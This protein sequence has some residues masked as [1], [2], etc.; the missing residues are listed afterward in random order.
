MIKKSYI[1]SDFSKILANK[2]LYPV[3]QFSLLQCKCIDEFGENYL[4]D[5]NVVNKKE[6]INSWYYVESKN[7]VYFNILVERLS[8]IHKKDLS[9]EFWKR[10]FSQGLMRQI[11]FLHQIF[12]LLEKKF[13]P[14]YFEFST[15]DPSSYFI[16]KDFEEQRN[17][18]GSFHGQEQLFSIYIDIF[19]PKLKRGTFSISQKK[20]TKSFF[21]YLIKRWISNLTKFLKYCLKNKR[22]DKS[23]CVVLLLGCF[24]SKYH[25]DNLIKKSSRKIIDL[26][27]I[28]YSK[29]FVMNDNL[30]TELSNLPERVDRFDKFFFGSLKFL[31]PKVFLEGL[32]YNLLCSKK[33]LSQYPKLSYIVSEAW[34]SDTKINLF[35]AYA[36][37]VKGVK[38]YYNEH[39]CIF[40]P[41]VGNFVD[42]QSRSIDKYLTFGWNSP[43]GKFSPTSSLF[44]FSISK[45]KKI[46]NLDILYVSNPV[47]FFFPTYSSS[48]SNWGYGSIE[49]LKYVKS[50]FHLLP[51]NLKHKISYRSYPKD[52]QITGLRFDKEKLLAKYL[53]GINFVSSFKF[54]GE[55]CKEQM[56]SSKLVI[57]DFLSTSYLES[58]HM[59]IPTICFW[60]PKSMSLKDDYADFFDDLVE[61]KIMHTNP[62]SAAIHLKE[63]HTNPQTWW[64]S[65]KIQDLK[66]NWLNRNFGQPDVLVNYLLK[67]AQKSF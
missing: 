39:N 52:Y 42:F 40:H 3:F 22:A 53:E 67:L 28:I 8:K 47:E 18:L 48:Y 15:L 27:N 63:I 34:L 35:R 65:K 55:T 33:L 59:N 2:A 5:F 58:L 24:F 14:D 37:E 60:D 50:F 21:N 49:H 57:V 6:L 20:S 13:K 23:R 43:N 36:Y 4:Q 29:K 51:Q 16:P 64:Q 62:S 12:A 31:F 46:V 41:F 66:N 56:L 26:T 32:E 10:S 61:A 44:P 38:T 54:K 1:V 9:T 17:F 30:R 19:Y 25:K 7:D 11:T 45:K